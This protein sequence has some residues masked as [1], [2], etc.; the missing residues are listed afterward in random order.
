MIRYQDAEECG[1]RFLE[2][3]GNAIRDL[4]FYDCS[5]E[6]NF[7]FVSR[8]NTKKKEFPFEKIFLSILTKERGL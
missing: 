4:F 3:M 6:F 7:R 5:K 8:A 1:V 2:R